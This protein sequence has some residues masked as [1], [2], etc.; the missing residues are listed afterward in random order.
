MAAP[1]GRWIG[2]KGAFVDREPLD[3]SNWSLC[4]PGC[5]ELGGPSPGATW[6]VVA[7]GFDDVSTLTLEP[8]IHCRGCCGWHGYL[9]AGEFV[10]C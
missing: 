3:G 2:P 10:S 4:C 8:S 6:R 5:G 9:R 7:G 1:G